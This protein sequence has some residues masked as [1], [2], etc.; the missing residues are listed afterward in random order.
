VELAELAELLGVAE[1]AKQRKLVGIAGLA[2]RATTRRLAW[3]GARILYRDASCRA[4]L[5]SAEPISI[6]SND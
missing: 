4:A 5:V 6:S 2:E 1:T 3:Q